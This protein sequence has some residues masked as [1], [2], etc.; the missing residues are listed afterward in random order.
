LS[1]D[2]RPGGAGAGGAA[3]QILHCTNLLFIAAQIANPRRGFS[4]FGI[5]LIR[6]NA[7]DRAIPR[8]LMSIIWVERF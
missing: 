3:G 2:W 6:V 1:K 4:V 5:E 8:N 7:W